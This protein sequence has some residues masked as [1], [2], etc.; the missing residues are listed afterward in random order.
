MKRLLL[1][2][3]L[4]IIGAAAFAQKYMPVIKTGTVLNYSAFLKNTGQNAELNLTITNFTDPVKM[5]WNVPGY[6][7]GIFEMPA[8]A[9]ESGHKTVLSPP[10]PDGVTKMGNDETLLVLSKAL[11]NDATSKKAFELNGLSFAVITDTAV[12][13]I[14][15]KQTDILHAVA[16]NGKSEIWVLNNPD[17]PLICQGKGITKGIDFYLTSIKE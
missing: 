6:G 7:T 16:A 15:N 5:Q 17:Y 9:L 1:S 3:A 10:E 11:Y 4:F 13:K 2:L 14:N 12:Y 8:K